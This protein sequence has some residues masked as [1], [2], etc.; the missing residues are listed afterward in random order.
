MP[1]PIISIIIP[2]FNG[3]KFLKRCFKTIN[4]QN[5]NCLDIIFID[6]NSTDNSYNY[7]LE[8]TQENLKSRLFKCENIGVSY[9]R[10]LGLKMAKGEYVSFLDVDDEIHPEKFQILL[11]LLNNYP[12]AVMAFGSTMKIYERTKKKHFNK[13]PLKIGMNYSPLHI[14]LWI[15]QLQHHPHISSTL[16]RNKDLPSFPVNLQYGEDIAFSIKLCMNNNIVYTEEIISTY[17][18]HHNSAISKANIKMPAVERYL[19]FYKNFLLPFFIKKRNHSDFKKAF[20]L[21][22]L[23]IFNAY[24]I[25]IKREKEYHFISK[26]NKHKIEFGK[27]YKIKLR[28]LLFTKIPLKIAFKLFFY[29]NK[30]HVIK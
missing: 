25:L 11:N 27:P 24:M 6:N 10:N 30:Y 16:I 8:Y 17:H 19:K 7:I 29:L 21:T 1:N 13:I 3:E 22:E 12:S 28:F 23:N 5:Y 20:Y 14:F 15:K 18:R 2:V 26:L 4:A 9:A